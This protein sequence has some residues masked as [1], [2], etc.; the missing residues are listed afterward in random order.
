MGTTETKG[1][2]PQFL[3]WRLSLDVRPHIGAECTSPAQLATARRWEVGLG[4]ALPR[5]KSLD[6]LGSDC[7]RGS[8]DYV[9]QAVVSADASRSLRVGVDDVRRSHRFALAT[10]LVPV[11]ERGCDRVSE[12]LGGC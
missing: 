8:A 11:F 10:C 2:N 3:S 9:V 7:W 6:L 4:N 12:A 1:A 5:P